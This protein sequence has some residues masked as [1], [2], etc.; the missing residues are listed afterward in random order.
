MAR[1]HSK[2]R[3]S[4]ITVTCGDRLP[5]GLDAF[6]AYSS[7]DKAVV[8]QIAKSLC[9]QNLKVWFDKWNLPPGRLF[10]EEIESILPHVKAI[11][12][13]VGAGGFGR[14]E[15]MEMRAAI[16]NFVEQGKPVI[17]VLLPGTLANVHLPLFLCAFSL[18]RFNTPKDPI[19]LKQLIWGITG[20]NPWQSSKASRVHP[21]KLGTESVADE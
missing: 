19:A 14:W 15:R 12:I 13:F 21:P 8:E 4:S 16:A 2:Q 3:R 20:I 10:Q 18:L 9:R 7:Q 5:A 1:Q 11:V 17:P 6:L